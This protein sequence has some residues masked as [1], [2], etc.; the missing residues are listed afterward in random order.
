[1]V[2]DSEAV[3]EKREMSIGLETITRDEA[4]DQGLKRYF[5]GEPCNHGHI[6]YRFVGDGKCVECNR[7]TS[8]RRYHK[9]PDSNK[10]AGKKWVNKNRDYWNSYMREYRRKKKETLK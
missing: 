3:T 7:I 10:K 1:M 2:R 6:V 4:I 8:K 9:N 5:T